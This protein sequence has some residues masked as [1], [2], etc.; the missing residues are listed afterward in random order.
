M[1]GKAI[2][3]STSQLE[4]IAVLNIPSMYGGTNVWGQDERPKRT[5]SL[6]RTVS[7]DRDVLPSEFQPQGKEE[8]VQS[9]D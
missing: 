5:W 7:L 6:S 2:D 1:D 3:L 9:N 8:S 4:G